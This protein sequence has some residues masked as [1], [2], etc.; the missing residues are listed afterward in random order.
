MD[1]IQ[2]F[3]EQSNLPE[4]EKEKLKKLLPKTYIGL[5]EKLVEQFVL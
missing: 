3:V 1:Q 4:A 5:S 2:A